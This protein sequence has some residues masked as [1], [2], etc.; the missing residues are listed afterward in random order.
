L[1]AIFFFTAC[2]PQAG[3]SGISSSLNSYVGEEKKDPL[4]DTHFLLSLKMAPALSLRDV[5]SQ[6]WELDEVDDP[7]WNLYFW[8]SVQNKRMYPALYLFRD[9]KCTKEPRGEIKLGTWSIDQGKRE[10]AL[11]FP[12]QN[13]Q[14]YFVDKISFTNLSLSS[15]EHDQMVHFHF[16]S[17]NIV[18]LNPIRDPFY[19]ANNRWRM[20]PGQAES[21]EQIRDR[22]RSFVWFYALFFK[23]NLDR[24]DRDISFIGLPN[25][26]TWYN[27][28]IAMQ[29]LFTLDK[30][31]INCFYS[32][33]QA[34]RAYDMVKSVL[35]KH[36]LKWPKNSA[37]WVEE[38]QKILEQIHEQI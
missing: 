25:C 32:E 3:K 30:K 13:Q 12:G 18:E 17:D 11:N 35:E 22:V 10:I 27:G 36:N 34:T 28:G 16:L 21:D 23:N 37:N 1:I 33:Q 9:M 38:L 8:D 31:W 5:L 2:R 24:K 7:F 29:P 19:P 6:R 26:F 14:V 20:K 4:P 15:W